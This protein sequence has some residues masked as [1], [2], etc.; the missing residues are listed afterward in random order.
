[1]SKTHNHSMHEGNKS[2]NDNHIQGHSHG[3]HSKD[4][5]RV[6][7]TLKFQESPKDGR[8]ERLFIQIND[9]KGKAIETLQ[10]SHEKMMHVIIV[11]K[12]LSYFDHVHPEYEGNG[13]FHVDIKFPNGGEYKLIADFI[14]KDSGPMLLSHWVTVRGDVI[15]EKPLKADIDLSKVV[16]DKMISLSFDELKHGHEVTMTF[17]ILDSK[18]MQ[19]VLDLEPYLGAIGHVVALSDGAQNYLHIHPIDETTKGPDAK[20]ITTFP[21]SGLY[22]LWGQFL[23]HGTL[24][25]VPFTIQVPQLEQ[26]HEETSRMLH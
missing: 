19:P 5:S 20:F 24:I 18:T 17:T 15:T 3:H 12:D 9:D 21:T 26:H 25:T 7:P 1:M 6:I 23:H 8:K 16:N 22:K 2:H 13:R 10:L 14:I 11:S 4:Q